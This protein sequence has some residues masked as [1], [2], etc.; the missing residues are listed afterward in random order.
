MMDVNRLRLSFPAVSENEAFARVAVCAFLAPLDPTV[1]EIGDIKTA[2]SEAVT[3]CVVH[4]YKEKK[5]GT[6]YIQVRVMK[7]ARAQIK[8]RDAGCGIADVSQAMEPMFSGS[9]SPER[10]GLGFSLMETFMDK[11]KV[12]SKV[13]RGTTVTLEKRIGVRDE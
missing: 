4:A 1:E 6:V 10:A 8:I 9:D 12:T 7:G 3:N 13:G 5:G 11:L 2:V